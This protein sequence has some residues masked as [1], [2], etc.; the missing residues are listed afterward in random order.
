MAIETKDGTTHQEPLKDGEPAAHGTRTGYQPPKLV[1]VGN[2]HSL[3]AGGGPSPTNDGLK[4][5][6]GHKAS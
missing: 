6:V 2:V 5:T 3:L 4:G 1:Y